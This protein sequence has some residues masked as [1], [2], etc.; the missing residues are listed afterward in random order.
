M[1][2]RRLTF[3]TVE[4][5]DAAKARK[6]AG[7]LLAEVKLGRDPAGDKQQRVEAARQGQCAATHDAW[8]SRRGVSATCQGKAE[9]AQLRGG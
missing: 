9:A 6:V 1:T 3:A 2:Q 7:E 5:L 4:M 8:R